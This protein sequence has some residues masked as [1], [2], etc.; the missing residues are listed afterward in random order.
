[1][2]VSLTHLFLLALNRNRTLDEGKYDKANAYL[3]KLV[4]LQPKSPEPHA[5]LALILA[6]T[7]LV[8]G[9][10]QILSALKKVRGC[11]LTLLTSLS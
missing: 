5:L 11:Y 10:A 7:D 4:T 3:K 2:R 8:G 1:M 6:G 9:R